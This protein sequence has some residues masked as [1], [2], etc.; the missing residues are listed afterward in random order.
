M[1][2][3]IRDVNKHFGN[4]H[5]LKNV[6]L[7]IDSG[8]ETVLTQWRA[9]KVRLLGV[10]TKSRVAAKLRASGWRY[11]LAEVRRHRR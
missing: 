7:D 8:E 3:Q 1:S 6:N 5:A 11:R 2:I 9:G 10:T 4:F